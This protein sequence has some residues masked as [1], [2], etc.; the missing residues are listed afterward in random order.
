M[1]ELKLIHVDTLKGAPAV[2]SWCA[3]ISWFYITQLIPWQL[4]AS[5]GHQQPQYWPCCGI[6]QS[7]HHK[8]QVPNESNCT[9]SAASNHYKTAAAQDN[10]YPPYPQPGIHSL[11]HAVTLTLDPWPSQVNQIR[12]LSLPRFVPN[13]YQ[14]QYPDMNLPK[15][16]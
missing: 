12:A 9:S 13:F 14:K 10:R 3:E 7:Q 6:S 11:S 4:L 1:L 15:N 2:N 16:F 5:P 8:N